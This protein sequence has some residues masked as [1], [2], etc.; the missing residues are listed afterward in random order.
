[1]TRA[2]AMSV[3]AWG[4]IGLGGAAASPAMDQ[5]YLY[6]R[7]G[8]FTSTP[9]EQ[10]LDQQRI[11]NEF[12]L[13]P[14][15]FVDRLRDRSWNVVIVRAIDL[16]PAPLHDEMI[17]LLEAHVD[18][19]GR[20]HFQVAD[21][22]DAPPRLL[23]LLGLVGTEDLA[24]PPSTIGPTDV[25]HL[26]ENDR[27][28]PPGTSALPGDAGEV[29]LP[30]ATSY[31]T[32]TYGDGGAATVISAGGRVIVN[33]AQWDQWDTMQSSLVAQT[34]LR[35]LRC[36]AELDGDGVLTIYEFLTFIILLERGNATADFDGNGRIDLF[37]FLTFS[38]VFDAG[39][40]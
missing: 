2:R 26:A 35:W 6:G 29:L 16:P 30:A 18:A 12:V 27:L 39:C 36:W 15:A 38:N 8:Q 14:A 17:D 19:G 11:P 33:G 22:Q 7:F 23:D 32:R 4:L 21:L 3:L 34:H 5:E 10:A 37:D 24:T 1:M 40:R 28:V 25:Q 31:V 20:L 9:I 13:D